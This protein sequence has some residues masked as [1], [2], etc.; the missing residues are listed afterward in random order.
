M[1]NGYE[2]YGNFVRNFDVNINTISYYFCH[3]HYYSEKIIELYQEG[4]GYSEISKRTDV[5]Q[6]TVEDTVNKWKEGQTGIF[7]N[8]LGYVDEIT[9][10]ARDMR[11]NGLKL[12]DLKMRFLNASI[13]KGLNVDLQELYS[14]H[15]ALRGYGSGL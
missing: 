6:S 13:L 8:A 1:T 15:D 9:G 14:L 5:A 7:D 4:Y 3:G 11:K 10:I 12:E 2:V